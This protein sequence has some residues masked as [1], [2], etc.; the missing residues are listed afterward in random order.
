VT[1]GK[2]FTGKSLN[3]KY[4]YCWDDSKF[5]TIRFKIFIQSKNT[6]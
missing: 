3:F 6:L 2:I 5:E 1:Y 4:D